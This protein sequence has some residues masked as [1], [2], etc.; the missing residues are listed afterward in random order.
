MSTVVAHTVVYVESTSTESSHQP[1]VQAIR[2]DIQLVSH[3]CARLGTPRTLRRITRRSRPGDTHRSCPCE[4]TGER[5]AYLARHH[6]D[7]R[8]N[9]TS[10][11][12]WHPSW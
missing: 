10:G 3:G 1:A 8:F 6:V 7:H 12:A 4:H 5:H 11:C 9:R 2:I